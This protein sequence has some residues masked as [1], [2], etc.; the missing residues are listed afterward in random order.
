MKIGIICGH[1]NG[2]PG[3]VSPS[4]GSEADF[5]RKLAPLIKKYLSNYAEVYILNTSINW[6][7]Y[8]Q[9]NF[10][11][12][13]KYDYII[14]LHGNAGANDNKGNGKTTG[15]EVWVTSSE[16]HITV[17]Q[18]ICNNISSLGL[19]NR[20]VK[21]CDFF[22]IQTIKKQGISC[23]LIENGFIDDYDDMKL[24]SNNIEDYCKILAKSI[25]EGFGLKSTEDSNTE[26]SE[27]YVIQ[28]GAFKEY[29]NA[30][31]ISDKINSIGYSNYI[32]KI[33]DYHKVYVGPFKN[34]ETA[35]EVSANLNKN[36]IDNYVLLNN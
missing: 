29:V 5:V 15:I 23:C 30:K 32:S 6:Y 22:V 1:G 25:A 9:N 7:N 35:S 36:K 24:I 18:E 28:C 3:A 10:F 11:D 2:D 4:F 19:K 34:Y 20:G 12:F 26:K 21:V 16:K 33:N 8:L 17:E 31:K 27:K 13:R 14:E